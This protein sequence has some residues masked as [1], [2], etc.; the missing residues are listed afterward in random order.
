MFCFAAL[1]T[2]EVNQFSVNVSPEL[3]TTVWLFL[4]Q[5]TVGFGVPAAIQR[6]VTV[7]LTLTFWSVKLLRILGASRSKHQNYKDYFE[8]NV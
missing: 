6:R 7:E 5:A 2:H 1:V 3:S 8:T 4:V